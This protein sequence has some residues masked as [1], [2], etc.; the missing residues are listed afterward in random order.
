MNPQ[1]SATR[2]EATLS[3]P[4]VSSS[5]DHAERVERPAREQADRAGRDAAAPRCGHEPVADPGPPFDE[6]IQR[7]AAEHRVGGIDERELDLLAP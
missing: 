2:C 7:S 5:R 4:Q 3:G 1:R 6:P